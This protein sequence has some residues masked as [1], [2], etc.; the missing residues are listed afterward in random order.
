MISIKNYLFKKKDKKKAPST[1]LS[2]SKQNNNFTF[3]KSCRIYT[4]YKKKMILENG[5]QW[6]LRKDYKY[7]I[8]KK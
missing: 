7:N 3:Q 5:T 4:F 1:L 2:K 6:N 8:L